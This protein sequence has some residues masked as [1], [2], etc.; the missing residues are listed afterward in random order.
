MDRGSTNLT[1]AL[2]EHPVRPRAVLVVA[3]RESI[4]TMLS[5]FVTQ[6]GHVPAIP[7][8]DEGMENAIHRVRPRVILIDFDH[9]YATSPRITRHLAGM[10]TKVVLCSSWHRVAEARTRAESLGWLFFSL[11]IDH[12]D[13]DLLLRTAMLI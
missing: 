5:S 10:S 2:A 8:D 6:S 1:A 9:P 11:P 13:F 7:L 3:S 12:K 4:A